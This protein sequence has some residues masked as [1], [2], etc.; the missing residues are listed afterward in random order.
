MAPIGLRMSAEGAALLGLGVAAAGILAGMAVLPVGGPIP[1]GRLLV[2]DAV[3]CAGWLWSGLV[4][5][6]EAFWQL[7]HEYVSTYGALFA[8]IGFA[9]L[10]GG[11]VLSGL[12]GGLALYV[13]MLRAGT[14]THTR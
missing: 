11:G 1:W 6:P 12:L 5:W 7:A 10:V 9:P 13:V 8:A 3:W 4:A 14:G 2:V